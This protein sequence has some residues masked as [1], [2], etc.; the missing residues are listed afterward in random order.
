[1]SKRKLTSQEISNILE[2]I[3]FNKGLP[4][5]VANT[6]RNNQI[7]SLK[8]QL[9][10]ITIYPEVIPSIKQEIEKQYYKTKIQAGEAVGIITA[11]SIG[12]RQTQSTLNSFHHAGIS[13]KTS[14]T[15][16]P[17]FSELMNATKEP[18][19]ESCTV[20][21]NDKFGG[22]GQLRDSIGHSMIELKFE[23]VVESDYYIFL[24][25]VV[26]EEWYELYNIIKDD[27][28]LRNVN[29]MNNFIRFKLKSQ[30]LW[31]YKLSLFVIAEKLE[32][33]YADIVCVFSPDELGIFDIYFNDSVTG[34]VQISTEEERTNETVLNSQSE[35]SDQGEIPSENFML[36]H[37]EGTVIPTL[38]S[39]KVSDGIPNII[40]I[41]PEKKDG[42]WV[43]E[44]EGSNLGMLLSHD[45]VDKTRTIS[46]NMW[47]IYNTLGIEAAR[48]F[49][50]E[51]FS[52]VVSSDGTY[53]ND[54]HIKLLV[55]TMT[56][57]G[58]ITSISRYGL[59]KENCGPLVKASFEESLENVTKAGL[60]GEIERIEGVSASVM[61]GKFTKCG[62]GLCDI[63]VDIDKL[64]PPLNVDSNSLEEKKYNLHDQSGEIVRNDNSAGRLVKIV[65]TRNP[66][67]ATPIGGCS[68]GTRA[69]E[70]ARASKGGERVILSPVVERDMFGRVTGGSSQ[71]MYCDNT[72]T[73]I[74]DFA[75]QSESGIKLQSIV[76]REKP[77]RI[78][79]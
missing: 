53:V 36:N 25:R 18:K 40:D 62:S 55:D 2:I 8:S 69:G 57:S 41:F 27:D 24:N 68:S 74:V 1:M 56:Y 66:P 50:I 35:R 34:R 17:R 15:G 76:K 28:I 77:R 16:V 9:E 67:L 63:L 48:N 75:G 33:E 44:T 4:Q 42:E 59:K 65:P 43:I 52:A 13:M 45:L 72:P 20:Y 78:V 19:A 11:Q 71:M 32:S 23:K 21:F 51:E 12:E 6:I 49:L 10:K 58:T 5:D 79:F 61:L 37:I 26:N 64:P 73:S 7:H 60:Y 31:E 30:I 46:N 14:I 29:Q 70:F 38:L 22:V 3:P 54:S 39:I 47:E